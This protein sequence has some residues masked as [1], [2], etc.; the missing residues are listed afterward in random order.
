[1]KCPALLKPNAQAKDIYAINFEELKSLGITNLILD[2]D[3][4]LLPRRSMNITP[5]LF[6]WVARRKEEGFKL[7]LASNSRYPGRVQYIGR[8]LNLPYMFF[9]LKPLPFAFW[10]AMKILG[11]NPKNTAM[12]GDQ[13]FMDILGA[14]LLGI[15]SIFTL[16]LTPE[17]F[18]PRKLMRLIEQKLLKNL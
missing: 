8:T 4:T 14:N 11:S 15:Y 17:T 3:D 12:I 9:G 7:C 2:V 13:L 5:K 18:E 10:K 16:L 6:E 1:M